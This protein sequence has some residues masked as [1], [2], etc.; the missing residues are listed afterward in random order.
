MSD[1]PPLPPRIACLPR[2]AQGWPIPY[3]VDRP[4]DGSID[5][6]V[7]HPQRMGMA[8]RKRLC[9]ICGQ[10]MGSYVAFVGGPLSIA[11]RQFS[12]PPAHRDCAEFALTV[13]PWLATGTHR[14]LAGMPAHTFIPAQHV[15]DNPGVFGLLITK[16]YRFTGITQ[17]GEPREIRWYTAGRL[18]TRSEVEAAIENARRSDQV[19]GYRLRDQILALLDKLPL[20]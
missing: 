19:Q 3:F 14:R 12:D 7:M 16:E 9:W 10:S 18:A 4:A 8:I 6:R 2:T 5:F 17:A 13:C 1:L 20:P 15:R 11:Q